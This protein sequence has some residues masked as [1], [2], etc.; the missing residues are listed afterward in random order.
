MR[1]VLEM[2]CQ[3]HCNKQR[4]QKY[5]KLLSTYNIQNVENL[6]TKTCL[7]FTRMTI[8]FLHFCDIFVMHI[9]RVLSHFCWISLPQV[10][11][12]KMWIICYIFTIFLLTIC[13]CSGRIFWLRS[14]PIRDVGTNRH[15]SWFLFNIFF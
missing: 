10:K 12:E 14:H 13:S 1:N 5:D 3:V 15:A 7:R 6:P 9:R 11:V 8:L 4:R 2:C